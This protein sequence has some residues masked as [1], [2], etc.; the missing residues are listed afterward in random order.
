MLE[1]VLILAILPFALYGAVLL[2]MAA[3]GVT[4]GV[5]GL[6]AS[7]FRSKDNY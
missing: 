7:L 3:L 5:L 4:G 2:L 1:F 6:I